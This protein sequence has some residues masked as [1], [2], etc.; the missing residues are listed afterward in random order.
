MSCWKN[1]THVFIDK[2]VGPNIV[3]SVTKFD[4]EK[5]LW[6]LTCESNQPGKIEWFLD[7]Q[8]IEE[9]ENFVIKVA[10]NSS[11]LMISKDAESNFLEKFEC[12]ISNKRGS[13]QAALNISSQ[14]DKS[15]LRNVDNPEIFTI[16]DEFITNEDFETSQ[17]QNE[18]S[19]S[20]ETLPSTE[21]TFSSKTKHKEAQTDKG[22]YVRNSYETSKNNTLA[23]KVEE[24]ENSDATSTSVFNRKV[25]TNLI[26]QTVFSIHKNET[27]FFENEKSERRQ[28]SYPYNLSGSIE[29]ESQTLHATDAPLSD[30]KG[31]EDPPGTQQNMIKVE[32][33]KDFLTDNGNGGEFNAN[34]ILEINISETVSVDD[35]DLTLLVDVDMANYFLESSTEQIDHETTQEEISDKAK[36]TEEN[37]HELNYESS[38]EIIQERVTETFDS[39][40][41][42]NI[43]LITSEEPI[44]EEGSGPFLIFNELENE[45]LLQVIKLENDDYD[46]YLPET[47]SSSTHQTQITS[48]T[49]SDHSSKYVLQ[50]VIISP[51]IVSECVVQFRHETL[52]SEESEWL[53]INAI[54]KEDGPDTYIGKVTLEHLKPG[55]EYQVRILTVYE[56]RLEDLKQTFFFTTKDDE[57]SGDLET[58]GSGSGFIPA[59]LDDASGDNYESGDNGLYNPTIEEVDSSIETSTVFEKK[60][61]S[62]PIQKNSK[63]GY[64][65]D[66]LIRTANLLLSIVCASVI[67]L[68]IL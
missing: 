62:K 14:K 48:H 65:S 18:I 64:E 39:E 13:D 19:I 58:S 22:D 35:S 5:E 24:V 45:N 2:N 54:L 9:S 17:L 44:I 21:E 59:I 49:T 55:S 37:D 26:P 38:T 25:T 52:E 15:I 33:F 47:S 7:G 53:Y 11:T 34:D 51:S 10:I 36:M 57:F 67:T 50:W 30:E 4:T 42:Q 6:I 68:Q 16:Q 46:G 32:S 12:K 63:R 61:I 28:S 29:V 27:S 40:E 60:R 41:F 8:Q 66:S 23:S 56:D 20:S 3:K 43:R 31:D 1:I